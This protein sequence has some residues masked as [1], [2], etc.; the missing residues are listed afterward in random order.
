M[1]FFPAFVLCVT[2][3]G[4]ANTVLPGT[5]LMIKPC[6]EQG[7]FASLPMQKSFTLTSKSQLELTNSSL[8]VM[9]GNRSAHTLSSTDRWRTLYLD[10]CV[11]IPLERSQWEFIT[12]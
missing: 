12:P 3:M 7:I 8:C 9:V 4:T 2:A 10:D 1:L 5:V 6:E 11:K